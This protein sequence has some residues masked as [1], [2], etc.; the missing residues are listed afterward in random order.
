MATFAMI[1]TV[2]GC[3]VGAPP[4]AQPTATIPP[5]S[6]APTPT[7]TIVA[8]SAPPA[9][10]AVAEQW[11][12]YQGPEGLR[13]VRMDGTDDHLFPST[14]AAQI[15]HPD[16]SPDG[17][18]LTYR[19]DGPGSATAIWISREDG[20]GARKLVD[21]QAP[22]GFV[23]DPAWSPDGTRIAF[24]RN[25]DDEAQAIHVVDIDSGVDTAVIRGKTGEGPIRPRWSPTGDRLVIEIERYDTG[26]NLTGTRLGLVDLANEA[27]AIEYLGPPDIAAGYPDWSPAGELILF[28]AGNDDPFSRA[29]DPVQL[30]TINADGS[31]LLQLTT[32]T[33]A[34]PFLALPAWVTGGSAI[35]V[36]VIHSPDVFTL[37]RANADG[38]DLTEILGE[39]GQPIVGAHARA[40]GR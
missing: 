16:W 18:W 10:P 32:R 9:T 28:Q 25:G 1:S 38:G 27:P 4:T 17:K 6:D 23:D 39:T 12:A 34:E 15:R 37:A 30:F 36:T 40:A 11:I 5:A 21:C 31:D 20:T 14:M 35:L 8:V 7:N 26:G 29:G 24:W 22:C 2:L 3:S 13:L 19:V 33:A